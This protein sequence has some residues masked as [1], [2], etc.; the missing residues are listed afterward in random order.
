VLPILLAQLAQSPAVPPPQ[1]A[2]HRDYGAWSPRRQRI[3]YELEYAP[4]WS[5]PVGSGDPEW[6]RGSE[7]AAGERIITHASPFLLSLTTRGAF[8]ILDGQSYALSLLQTLAVSV[9]LGPL[10]PDVGG[11]FS[12]FTVDAVHGHWSAEALSPRAVAGL[13]LHFGPFRVGAHAF[14]EVLWR[15]W[16]NDSYLV[17]GVGI[18]IGG[19]QGA[20][21][22]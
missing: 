14:G 15:W 10:E 6:T 12:V 2:W 3:A 21:A 11:G 9:A 17:R 1:A 18:E 16:G 22:K 7:L 4:I 20:V 8:R 5:R 13:W 19:E